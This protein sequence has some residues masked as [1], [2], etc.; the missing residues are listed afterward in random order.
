MK[1]FTLLSAS[2]IVAAGLLGCSEKTTYVDTNGPDTIV[3]T[4]QINAQDWNRAAQE[5]VSSLL[6][7]GTL[8]SAPRQPA[9]MAIS[10]I[11]NK[12]DQNVDTDLLT[13][14]IRVSLN[15]SG[16]VRTS[17]TIGL[18]GKAEDP[19]AK[20]SKQQDEF[21][22]GTSHAPPDL[23]D[24]TL[25][26]KILEERARAGDTRQVTYTFQLSLTDR[27]GNA[28]WEEQ[29]QITKQGKRPSVGW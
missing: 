17:T 24:Y 8:E 23:P 28:A 5:M 11:T 22:N 14:N 9:I 18:N 19:L 7:S 4:D 3:S 25:S 10:R 29:R 12:T 26:G 16:K 6:D 21:Y 15:K 20:G 13:K 1:H 2:A 27:S